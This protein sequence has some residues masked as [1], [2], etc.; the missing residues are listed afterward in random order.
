MFDTRRL[1]TKLF[2]D[3][4]DAQTEQGE[5]PLLAPSNENYGYVGKP[6]FKPDGLLWRDAAVGRVLVRRAVGAYQRFGDR[7]ALEATYPAMRRYL[8]DWIPRWTGRDGDES[9][10]TLTS[11]SGDW[12]PPPGTD[13]V[14]KLSATAYYAL[15]AHIAAD[16]ARALGE[17]ADAAR[18]DTLFARIRGAFNAKFLARRRRVPRLDDVDRTGRAAAGGAW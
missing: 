13:P 14:I 8:D 15:F 4:R 2:Q 16:A 10:Y 5:V 11:G 7:R 1:Y 12:D 18:Y 3:M 6:A 17:T 9:P